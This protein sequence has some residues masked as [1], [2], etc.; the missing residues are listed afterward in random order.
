MGPAFTADFRRK[1]EYLNNSFRLFNM[2]CALV[3]LPPPTIGYYLGACGGGDKVFEATHRS[4][5]GGCKY[6]GQV[7]GGRLSRERIFLKT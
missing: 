7:D 5:K 1:R 4:G 6:N 2:L 3:V